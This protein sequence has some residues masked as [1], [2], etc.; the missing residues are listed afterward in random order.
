MCF[1]KSDSDVS[2]CESAL[3]S[4]LTSSPVVTP[5]WLA[6]VSMIMI[7]VSMYGAKSGKVVRRMSVLTTPMLAR[8]TV[9]RVLLAKVKSVCLAVAM[10]WM[11][12]TAEAAFVGMSSGR[13]VGGPRAIYRW[14]AVGN[15]NWVGEVDGHEIPFC[16]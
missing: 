2:G 11:L 13:K 10:R 12:T 14:L 6:M 16:I 9:V 4:L 7:G 8:R 1:V 3:R 5:C 15:A